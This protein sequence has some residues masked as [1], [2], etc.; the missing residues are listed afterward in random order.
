MFNHLMKKVE[1]MADARMIV[2]LLFLFL[3]TIFGIVPAI[4]PKFQTLDT[5]SSYTPQKAYDLLSSYGE[6]SRQS[7][8][9]IE[10][11]LDLA[12]PLITAL[13]FSLMSLYTF[14]RAFPGAAWPKYVAL[15][16]FAV[17]LADYFE[18]ACI[19]TMLISYP[20]QLLGLARLANIF[21]LAKATLWPLQMLFVIGLIGWPVRVLFT[22]WRTARKD[23]A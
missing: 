6:A 10:V 3:L 13:M 23:E 22:R 14:K 15:A 2:L 5:L 7:Y 16:P 9:L 21:T 19:V 4:Y 12:Y 20:R 11:T 8:A 18:N 17:M 1:K